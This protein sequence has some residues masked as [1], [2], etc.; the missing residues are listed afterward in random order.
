MLSI[1]KLLQQFST[2][3]SGRLFF[4]PIVWHRDRY[5]L[6]CG[7]ET[8]YSIN[9][10]KT[11][12]GLYEYSECKRQF[13]VTTKTPMH[14]TK[15]SFIKW[16]MAIYYIINSSKGIASIVLAF[17]SVCHKRPFERWAMPSKQ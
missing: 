7:F 15:L 14:N 10:N 9:G 5:C 8:T 17:G 11:R 1:D 12:V 13:P 3:E 4:E 6:H 2:V 16:L